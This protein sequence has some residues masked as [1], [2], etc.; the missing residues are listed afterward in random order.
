MREVNIKYSQNY[1]HNEALVKELIGKSNIGN[2]DVVY[3]IGAGKGI[4]TQQLALSCKKVIS[5]E[6]DSQLSTHLKHRFESNP[7]I[8]IINSD[9]LQYVF[10]DYLYCKFFSNIPFNITAELMMKVLELKGVKDIYFIMQYEAFLKY[11]GSPYYRDCFKSLQYKPFYIMEILHEFSPTDFSPVPKARIILAHIYPRINTD[12][13]KREKDNY[14]DFLSFMFLENGSSFKD[15]SK[16]IF[17]YE[18]VKRISKDYSISLDSSLLDLTIQQWNCIFQ[19]YLNYVSA[20]KKTMVDGSFKYLKGEQ[21][22][23]EK[24]HKNR[25]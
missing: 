9:F 7:N 21:S 11:A 15:K 12:I 10:K 16:R 17:S 1:L 2:N 8:E 19:V 4:I 22:K 24:I 3:E 20:E 6:Y 18:Q 13:C 25:R 14:L 5:F 23:L